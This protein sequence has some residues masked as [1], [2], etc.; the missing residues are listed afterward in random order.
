MMI[1][2]STWQELF[3]AVFHWRYAMIVAVIL[4]AHLVFILLLWLRAGA[5]LQPLELTVYDRML[6]IHAS[7]YPSDDRVVLVLCD[8]EDQ[9]RYGWPL[10]DAT[11]ADL[12]DRL[13]HYS[14]RAIGLDLYRDLPVPSSGG[15]DYERLSTLFRERPEI[16]GITKITDEHGARVD[17]PPM[18]RDSGRVSFND[19]VADTHGI[20]RRGLLYMSD[21]TEVH[22]YLGLKLALRWLSFEKQGA[23]ADAHGYLALG[24]AAHGLRPLHSHFGG[25]DNIDAAGYQFMLAYPGAPAGFPV[26]K[27]REILEWNLG[28]NLLHDKIIL[29]GT[30]AEATP[31]FFFTP[32]SATRLPGVLIHAYNISQLLHFAEGT[33]QPLR[34]WPEHYE[35]LWLWFWIISAALLSL[36]TQNLLQLFIKL[37]A[38]LVIIGS[39]AMFAFMR[40]WWIPVAT[41]MLG[42][43]VS[44]AL[45]V[46][47][48]SYQQ[49]NERAVLMQLFSRHVSKDVAEVIWK[50]RDHY[51]N[52]GRLRSQRLVATI[53]FTDLRNFTGLSEQMEPQA[54]MDWLNEYMEVMVRV[55]EAHHGQVN[56]FIGDALMAV[57]GVPIPRTSHEQISADAVNAIHCALAMRQELNKLHQY[58]HTHGA[59]SLGMRVGIFTGPVVAGSVGGEMRQEYTVIGDSVNTA[60][61]LESLDKSIDADLS[62]RILISQASL[63]YLPQGLFEIE[64]IGDIM[65]K[66]K[67]DALQVYRVLGYCSPHSQEESKRQT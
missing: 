50:S 32:I 19:V 35:K 22:T 27:L 5:W 40:D 21:D 24:Q 37:N 10:S 16:I 54:L 62:C 44:I 8:D 1:T 30:N 6:R 52:K 45:S 17:P 4:L 59:P 65:V 55:V 14:P 42:W 15:K 20:I 67:H 18:L 11:L 3:S 43:V 7:S 36:R 61:R 31:D 49:R 23:H 46:A 29:I 64:A 2:R 58:W 60:S 48:L 47:Y 26:L 12:F 34:D 56:K 66:G 9:R 51:L 53:L 63:N 57:F 33:Y 39:C 13:L 41:P 28:G 38:G 25:Y